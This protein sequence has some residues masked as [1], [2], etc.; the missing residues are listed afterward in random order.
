MFVW[1]PKISLKNGIR[2]IIWYFGRFKW[3]L[4]I[5]A[6]FQL[7]EKL[8]TFICDYKKCYLRG[9]NLKLVCMYVRACVCNNA[10][11]KIKFEVLLIH[12]VQCTLIIKCT[13]FS[14][15]TKVLL[16]IHCLIVRLMFS[17]VCLPSIKKHW[18]FNGIIIIYLNVSHILS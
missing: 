10:C 18:L 9:A 12:I 7:I 8:I 13:K 11:L 16:F 4:Q 2:L 14:S 6:D 3:I 15:T 1:F 5:F 17:P